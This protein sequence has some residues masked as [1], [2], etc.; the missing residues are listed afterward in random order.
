MTVRVGGRYCASGCRELKVVSFALCNIGKFVQKI[1]AS[2]ARKSW[3][4]L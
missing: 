4:S 1:K 3:S 2:E